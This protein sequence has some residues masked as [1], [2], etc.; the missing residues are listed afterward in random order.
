MDPM[1]GMLFLVF[2]AGAGGGGMPEPGPTGPIPQTG[3]SKG[4]KLLRTEAERAGLSDDWTTFLAAVA[5]HESRWNPSVGLGLPG[6]IEVPGISLNE[7]KHGAWEAK[8]AVMAYDRNEDEFKQC[9]WPRM[10]YGFGSGGWFGLLPANALWSFK[11]TPGFCMDPQKAVFDPWSS[12]VLGTDYARR[13]MRWKSF[14]AGGATWKV[15]NR[16]W[17]APGNMDGTPA[18][19]VA[20]TDERWEKALKALG[21]PSSWGNRKVTKLPTGWDAWDVYTAGLETA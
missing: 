10:R 18:E 4:L 9:P 14:K 19:R 15:L 2:A 5:Y 1:L 11:G 6:R 17:A 20:K 8:A 12:L 21:V 7:G 3:G 16:G 13:L